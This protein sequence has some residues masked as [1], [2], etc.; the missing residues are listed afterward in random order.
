MLGSTWEQ[1]EGLNEIRLGSYR[2]AIAI[3][4]DRRNIGLVIDLWKKQAE[5]DADNERFD[6][7]SEDYKNALKLTT[8]KKEI[9][10]LQKLID[11]MDSKLKLKQ[12]LYRN[13][14]N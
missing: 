11:T 13:G 6:I 7:A 9:E 1:D 2:R 8:D 10:T 5:K 3:F 14:D 4:K 12:H